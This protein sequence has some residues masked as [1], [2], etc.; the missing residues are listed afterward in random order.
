MEL[1]GNIFKRTNSLMRNFF[2]ILTTVIFIFQG[3]VLDAEELIFPESLMNKYDASLSAVESGNIDG[4]SERV[5]ELKNELYRHGLLSINSFVDDALSRSFA[6]ERN[7]RLDIV[8]IALQVSPLNAKYWLYLGL[9]DLLDFNAYAFWDDIVNLYHATRKN[10]VPLLKSL[11]IIFGFSAMFLLFFLFFFSIAIMLKYLPSL[12][13]DILR[14]KS[15]QILKFIIPPL[16]IF[17]FLIFVYTV[18]SPYAV[19]FFILAVFSPYMLNRELLLTLLIGLVI[20]MTINFNSKVSVYSQMA[21]FPERKNLLHLAY[22]IATGVKDVKVDL[23]GK[24]LISS[25]GK[26]RYAFLTGNYRDSIQI[27]KDLEERMEEEYSIMTSMG[28]FYLGDTKG[29]ISQLTKVLRDSENNPVVL[30]NLYQLYITDYQFDEAANIQEKAWGALSENRPFQINPKKIGER[31]LIP[32]SISG[33]F[34]KVFMG[35]LGTKGYKELPFRNLWLNPLGG[36][37][38]YFAFLMAAMVLLRALTYNRYIIIAC[39]ICGDRQLGKV[40]LKK[41]NI[42]QYCKSK[43]LIFSGM[44]GNP[45]KSYQIRTHKKAVRLKSLV[46]PGFGFLSAGSISMFFITTIVISLL[47]S[48]FVL[49]YFSFPGDYSPLYAVI[50]RLGTV[51]TGGLALAFY[52]I[53]LISNELFLRRAHSKH[54]IDTV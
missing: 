42:C 2:L 11:Y 21:I 28:K 47:L 7:S 24:S 35:D 27:G 16:I 15:L 20:F 5:F 51:I 8:R 33:S 36:S 30:F 43:S 13:S 9:N 23:A 22:G 14:I 37:W 26:V 52:A 12:V 50:S 46:V 53:F 17:A 41:E 39:R 32:P 19:L 4:F 48:L 18:R 1:R 49:F 34:F 54:K 44:A 45:E 38:V 10:P 31:I 40:S 25:A 6:L 3:D 29:A